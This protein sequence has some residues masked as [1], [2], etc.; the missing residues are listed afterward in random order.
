MLLTRCLILSERNGRIMAKT[1]GKKMG[2]FIK[3]MPRT[4]KGKE[5]CK[6]DLIFLFGGFILTHS[7]MYSY[8]V[9]HFLINF[10]KA[11][12]KRRRK[13]QLYTEKL[14]FLDVEGVLNLDISPDIQFIISSLKYI[15][16]R[17]NVSIDMYRK[18]RRY[19][20]C[21]GRSY[22]QSVSKAP[23]LEIKNHFESIFL[24]LPLSNNQ[25]WRNEA[26]TKNLVSCEFFGV[27]LTWKQCLKMSDSPHYNGRSF[28]LI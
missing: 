14:I 19:L 28:N 18:Y 4:F 27:P 5:S 1:G 15:I 13:K 10:K 9:F 17:E 12:N 25:L 16:F 23:I 8:I 7:I 24:S 3:W 22:L 21:Q 26:H 6:T 2:S 20:F 11:S